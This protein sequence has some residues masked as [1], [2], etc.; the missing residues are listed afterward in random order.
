MADT[1]SISLAEFKK[2][3]DTTTN[4]AAA[5]LMESTSASATI[6]NQEADTEDV[7]LVHEAEFV[8]HN[9]GIITE[10]DDIATVTKQDSMATEG[11][12]IKKYIVCPTLFCFSYSKQTSC[13]STNDNNVDHTSYF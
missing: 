13:L 9:T 2:E 8:T 3:P 1:E 11:K 5:Q 6:I 4:E 7:K 10:Y 12:K